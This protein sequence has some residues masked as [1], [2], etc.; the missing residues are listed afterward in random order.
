MSNRCSTGAIGAAAIIEA[1]T[2]A[3][4]TA[5]IADTMDTAT[6]T[7]TTMAIGSLWQPSAPVR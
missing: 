2:V 1:A 6:A 4:T 3:V 7:V 5:A